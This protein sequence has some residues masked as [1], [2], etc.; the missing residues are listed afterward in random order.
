MARGEVLADHYLAMNPIEGAEEIE[1]IDTMEPAFN[2]PAKWIT[3]DK[4]ES[5]QM[6][7]YTVIDPLSVIMTHLS[8]VMRKHAHEMLGRRELNSL[9]ENLRKTNKEQVDE[10]VPS[11]IGKG[12]LHKIL[13]NLLSEEVPIKDLE[14]ILETAA[15]YAPTVK[16]TDILTEY[17][18]QR[19]RR[20]ITR[21]YAKNG[22]L[23]VLT[24]TPETE[25]AIMNGVNKNG[26][27]SYISLTPDVMKKLL[28]SHMKEEKKAGRRRGR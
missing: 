28:S 22:S 24:I 6:G 23:K 12:E 2:I 5:A 10:V 19:L 4:C 13:C 1:G 15:E 8:E 3:A 27:G 14:T 25:N 9:L 21:K 11:V 16:D 20:T 18:R 7:G 26:S 17:V